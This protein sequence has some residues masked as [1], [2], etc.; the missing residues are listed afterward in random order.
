MSRVTAT[1]ATSDPSVTEKTTS[2]ADIFAS[3][4]CPVRRSSATIARKIIAETAIA[5]PMSDHE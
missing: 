1:V 5:R 4:R 2:Y 3:A